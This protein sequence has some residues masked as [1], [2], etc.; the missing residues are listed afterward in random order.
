[1]KLAFLLMFR[2]AAPAEILHEATEGRSPTVKIT[3]QQWFFVDKNPEMK[4]AVQENFF[5][6]KVSGCPPII[7]RKLALDKQSDP[8]EFYKNT[9]SSQTNM[10]LVVQYENLGL[11]NALFPQLKIRRYEVWDHIFIYNQ[12]AGF[13][14]NHVFD[15]EFR[16]RAKYE[17]LLNLVDDDDLWRLTLPIQFDKDT[18]QETDCIVCT[19]DFTIEQPIL[20]QLAKKLWTGCEVGQDGWESSGY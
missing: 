16:C 17:G 14:G 2:I 10:A 13:D 1:M 15:G 5:G 3:P 18:V 12:W 4:Y 19:K 8:S 11:L 20:K 6:K 7:N 9:I